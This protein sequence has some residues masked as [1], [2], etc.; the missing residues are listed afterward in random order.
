VTGIPLEV[1]HIIPLSAGGETCLEN[2]CLACAP[3][4][5]RKGVRTVATDPRTGQQVLLFHP[6]RQRWDEHFTWSKDG[7]QIVGLTPTGRATVIAL[8][9][10]NVLRVRAREMWIV[11]GWHP[12][13]E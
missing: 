4:N 11:A 6:R 9:L 3:C 7:A 1:D 10:N 5:R 2:L 8:D 13:E 12:P